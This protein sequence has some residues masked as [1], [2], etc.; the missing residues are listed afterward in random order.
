[1][2]DTDTPPAGASNADGQDSG[3][4]HETSSGEQRIDPGEIEAVLHFSL[5]TL[6]RSLA[7]IEAISEGYV[8]ELSRE[9]ADCV[10]IN[11]NGKRLVRGEPVMVEDRVGI[12]V[13]KIDDG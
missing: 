5:G 10:D 2:A 8:F 13:V 6:T 4:Q 3:E 9:P 12:R 11:I 1:M 7:G